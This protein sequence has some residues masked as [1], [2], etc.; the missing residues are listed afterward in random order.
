MRD[1]YVASMKGVILG[2]DPSANIVDASHG[3]PAH[4]V[5]FAAFVLNG[6]YRYFPKSTIHVVVVDPGVGGPRSGMVVET[7]GYLFIGPDNGVFTHVLR[8]GHPACHEIDIGRTVS[9]TFHGRDVF[10]PAAARLSLK[11]DSMV[12]GKRIKSPVLIDASG[13]SVGRGGITGEVIHIDGFGNAITNISSGAI[14]AD[15]I[16]G[17]VVKGHRIK[18][19]VGTYEQCSAGTLCSLIDSFDLL[20]I[21]VSAGSAHERF[22]IDRGDR[23]R[24]VW[25]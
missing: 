1:S 23:V 4:D 22:G 3:I 17:I 21:A 15:R 24:V 8:E 16:L 11:R 25:K 5:R 9:G 18:G 20:E 13:P 7:K 2:I 10:A 19:L 14:R 12:I 6:Y